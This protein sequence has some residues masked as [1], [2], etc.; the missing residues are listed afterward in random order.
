MILAPSL[1]ATG[2]GI[3]DDIGLEPITSVVFRVGPELSKITTVRALVL[4]LIRDLML[5]PLRWINI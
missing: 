5:A 4:N 2:I 3:E 1:A